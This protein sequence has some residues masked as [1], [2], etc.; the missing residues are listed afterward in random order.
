MC[1][2]LCRPAGNPPDQ[3]ITDERRQMCRT[4]RPDWDE[5][6][7]AFVSGG[8]SRAVQFTMVQRSPR[9]WLDTGNTD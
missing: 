8:L 1:C 3:V 4:N 5:W 2:D 9:A 7:G 6:S